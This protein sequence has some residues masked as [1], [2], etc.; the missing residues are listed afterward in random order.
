MARIRSARRSAEP[1]RASRSHTTPPRI[2]I[3]TANLEPDDGE[4]LADAIASLGRSAGRTY[5]G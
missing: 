5:T 2:R 3:T 1:P 4:R